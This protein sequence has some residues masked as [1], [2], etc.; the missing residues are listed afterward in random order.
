MRPSPG[1]IVHFYDREEIV[2]A[3][4]RDRDPEPTVALIRRVR[5]EACTCD[6]VL[7]TDLGPRN[8]D[9]VPKAQT[10]MQANAWDWPARM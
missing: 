1:R 9:G 3:R 6:L 8:V 7:F 10:P 4:R 5:N 2:E